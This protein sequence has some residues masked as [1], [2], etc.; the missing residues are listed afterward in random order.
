MRVQIYT[1]KFKD[2]R[3]T[4]DPSCNYLGE[5]TVDMSNTTGGKSRQGAVH[6]T[7]GGVCFSIGIKH[8][9]INQSINVTSPSCNIFTT[10]NSLIKPDLSINEESLT[11]Q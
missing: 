2:P 11:W 8:Q 4:D 10:N 5:L 6:L 3:Y 1:S 7:F 9:S